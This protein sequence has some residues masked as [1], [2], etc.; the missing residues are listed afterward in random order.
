M[1]AALV[2]DGLSFYKGRDNVQMLRDEF[3]TCVNK[4]L[5][6]QSHIYTSNL[7]PLVGSILDVHFMHTQE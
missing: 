2:S 1:L 4:D 6:E 5:E 7:L 3:S